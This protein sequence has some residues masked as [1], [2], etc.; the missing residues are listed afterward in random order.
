MED[1]ATPDSG[2]VW[3][4][5]LHPGSG[6]F[7]WEEEG[8]LVFL[9]P[10]FSKDCSAPSDPTP[11]D[12]VFPPDIVFLLHEMIGD[13]ADLK[14]GEIR[15]VSLMVPGDNTG[16]PGTVCRMGDDRFFVVWSE[17]GNGHTH[18]VHPDTA[19]QIMS[20]QAVRKANE[21]LNYFNTIVRH[22]ISNLVMGIT[23]YLDIIDEIVEDDEVR[24]LVK[25][26]RDLGERIRRVG[27]L[28]RSYQDLG[29]RPP[30]FVEAGETV[31][32]ILKRHEFAGKIDY[33]V[34][35]PELFIYVDRLFD[36]VVYE[37]VR[38]SLQF[39][40]EGVKMRFSYH[41]IPEGLSIILED[42]GPGIHPDFKKRIFSRNYADRKGYGL[43][44]VSEILDI[45]G[46]TIQ[47]TGTYEKGARFELLFPAG[48][49]HFGDHLV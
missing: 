23:G 33:T 3:E 34:D 17:T 37:M 47:E 32:R 26:G 1:K 45:T 8:E 9:S 39:G 14:P 43:Y 18:E 12:A 30:S 36:V 22:D 15:S 42:D 2:Y 44:L 13:S 40:G 6:W 28:T 38:N 7:V 29:T 10:S 21:K 49:F 5:Y 20:L 16:W 24:L 48:M 19:E 46:S 27:E 31:L 11:A 25:K 4:A 35:L 41:I